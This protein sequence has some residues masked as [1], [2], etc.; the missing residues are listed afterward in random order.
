MISLI[1]NFVFRE[2]GIYVQ[3]LAR[4]IVKDVTKFAVIFV[5]IW[6]AFAGSVYLALSATNGFD[7]DFQ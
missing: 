4:I 5:I 2:Y 1:P 3:T 7:G 6:V